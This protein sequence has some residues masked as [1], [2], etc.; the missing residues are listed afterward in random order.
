MIAPKRITLTAEQRNLAPLIEMVEDWL[1]AAGFDHRQ[2]M[3]AC[4]A[5][6]EIFVNICSYA[7]SAGGEA[8]ISLSLT[9]TGTAQ[10]ELLDHGQ[11]F[12]PLSHDAPN[13]PTPDEEQEE[14]GLGIFMARKLVD[15]M[16][17]HRA[18]GDNI[19][20]IEIDKKQED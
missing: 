7:Y 16:H 6:E 4:V 12:D 19:L 17:Y 11:P 2:I 8:V 14:G 13:I 3:G 5:T 9:D 10:I 18:G 15:R 20:T 1:T